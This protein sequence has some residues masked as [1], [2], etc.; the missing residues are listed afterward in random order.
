MQ[1]N[2]HLSIKPELWSRLQAVWTATKSEAAVC[3]V[4]IGFDSANQHEGR[5]RIHLRSNQTPDSLLSVINDNVLDVL[6]VDQGYP[7]TDVTIET[8]PHV[9]IVMSGQSCGVPGGIPGT[10]T[11][12][13]IDEL[14]GLPCL[15]TSAHVLLDL[16]GPLQPRVTQPNDGTERDII[17]SRLRSICDLDGI[18]GLACLTGP[19]TWLPV[20][21]GTYD[22]ITAIDAVS[23]GDT[24]SRSTQM[25]DHTTA[26]V[27]GIGYYRIGGDQDVGK[28][29]S[30]WMQGFR[31]SAAG[32]A[33]LSHHSCGCTGALWYDRDKQAAVGLQVTNGETPIA[34]HMPRIAQRLQIRL[35]SY[36]DLIEDIAAKEENTA[37]TVFVPPAPP[38]MNLTRAFSVTRHIWPQLQ[39]AVAECP[40]F[41]GVEITPNTRIPGSLGQTITAAVAGSS[42]FAA[43]NVAVDEKD[44]RSCKDLN[45]LLAL[46]IIAIGDRGFSLSP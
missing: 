23:L 41:E 31:M 36:D 14:T 6:Y 21:Q 45:D 8:T 37:A 13:V 39:L 5:L 9:P 11:A 40:G 46:L 29:P 18:A 34:C 7:V 20:V 42:F 24:L 12:I 25:T 17:A 38:L 35:A 26:M 43:A 3:G 4:D 27:D 15:L 33:S 1:E 32:S 16:P 19:R 44:V 2:L 22:V 10:I 30:H 28:I